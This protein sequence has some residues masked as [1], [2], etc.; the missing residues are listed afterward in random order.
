M[1]YRTIDNI[2]ILHQKHL[3]IIVRQNYII[4]Y[5]YLIVNTL[6]TINTNN[7]VTGRLG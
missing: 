7:L 3:N 6:S 1:Q 5:H 4:A 2:V